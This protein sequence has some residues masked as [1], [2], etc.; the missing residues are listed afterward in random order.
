M[1]CC[2]RLQNRIDAAGKRGIAIVVRQTPEFFIFYVQSRAVAFGEE[3]SLPQQ[4]EQTIN[5][6]CSVG[7]LYCPWCGERLD[8][9]VEAYSAEI[10][11]IAKQHER[12]VPTS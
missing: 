9:V 6:I 12:F 10:A 4:I 5:L 8:D 3:S 7:I 11:D 2:D 1:L